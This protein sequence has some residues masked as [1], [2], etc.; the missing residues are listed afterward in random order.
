MVCILKRKKT[1]ELSH[2]FLQSDVQLQ[3][4]RNAEVFE[5]QLFRFRI[6]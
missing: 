2:V 6:P 5:D 1:Q 4:N 3:S